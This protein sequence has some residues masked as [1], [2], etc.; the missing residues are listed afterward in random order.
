ML[1]MSI[2]IGAMN[3]A[4][5]VKGEQ[6]APHDD[7]VPPDVLGGDNIWTTDADWW[8][9]PGDNIFHENKTIL[10][11]GNLYVNGSL[12]LTNVTLEMGNATYDGKYNITVLESGNLIIQDYDDDPITSSDASILSSNTTFRF[13]FQAYPGSKLEL[14]NSE[15][16]DCGWSTSPYVDGFGLFIYTDWANITGNYINDSYYGVVVW[17]SNNVTIANN[18]INGVEDRGVYTDGAEY[19]YLQNNTLTNIPNFAFYIYNSIFI[20]ISYNNVINNPNAYG[21][22]LAN[23]GGHDVYNNTLDNNEIGV[24][25]HADGTSYTTAYCYIFE[26]DI[27]NNNRGIHVQGLDGVSAVQYIY[28]FDNEIYS[29]TEYGIILYGDNGTFAVNNTFIFD[30]KVYNNGGGGGHGIR[31]IGNSLGDV[32]RVYCLDNEVRDNNIAADTTSGYFLDSVSEIY[33]LGDYIARN[34]RNLWVDSSDNVYVTNASLEK[35]SDPGDVDIRIEDNYGNPPS[36]Y[37]LNTTFDKGSATVLDTGSFLNVQ[38]YLHIRV[39]QW[40]SGADNV[41]VW[42]NNSFGNPDPLSGQ[43]FNTNIGNDGWI[44]W[45]RV[46]EFIRT[47]TSTTYYTPHHIDAEKGSANGSADSNMNLSKEVIIKLNSPPTADNISSTSFF[48]LREQEINITANG[49]DPEDSEDILTPYFEYSDPNVPDW[50]TTYLGNPIYIGIAPSGFWQV[51][52]TPPG[53]APLGLYE[54]RVRFEDPNGSSSG[55]KLLSGFVI[56]QGNPPTANAGPDDTVSAGTTHLFNGSGSTDDE[57][58]INYTWN[59]TYNSTD[60]YLYGVGPVF[61]FNIPGVYIVT[62]RVEDAQG[63]WDT[64]S[65]QITVM[66]DA[67]PVVYAGLDGSVKVN[68]QYNFSAAGSWDNVGIVWYNWTFDDG[69]Y[70]NGTNIT[71]KHTYTS[72]G[73][74]TVTLNCSDAAGNWAI[75]TV[76]I[77]VILSDPPVAEAGP[78]NSTDEGSQIV[79]NGSASTDDFGI[80]LYYWDVDASNGLDWI[81]PDL[82]GEEVIWTYNIPGIYE[83]TLKVIDADGGWDTAILNATVNDITP[84]VANAGPT[85]STDE[86]TEYIFDGT[87][88]YDPEGGTIISYYWDFGDGNFTSGADPQPSHTYIHPGYYNVT[89]NVTDSA[90]HWDTTWVWITVLDITPPTANAGL[91]NVTDEGSPVTFDG[92]ASFDNYD[93]PGAL[94]YSWDIDDSDGVDWVTPD[95]TGS[96]PIHV[97]SQPGTY[98]VTLNV[99][100]TAG[101][102]GHDTLTIIVNDVTA[103]TANAGPDAT[104]NEDSPHTFDGSGSFD[105]V[106]IDTYAWDIDDS[107]GVDWSSPDKFG[108]N[109]SH[110][111]TDP[112]TYIATLNVTDAMGYW[113]TDTVIINVTDI[114]PPTVSAGPVDYDTVNNG[115]DYAFNGSASTDNSGSIAFYNWSFGDGNYA[116]G[117][118]PKPEHTYTTPGNYTVILTVT[119]AAGNS[120]TDTM[121]IKVIDTDDP[122]AN[123]GQNDTVNEDTPYQFNGSASTDDVGIETYA[124][125][126]DAS[127]GVDWAS[128][129]HTGMMPVHIYSDPDMYLVTLKVTDADGNWGTDTLQITVFDITPPIAN[130]GSPAT[131]DEDTPYLLDGSASYDPEGGTIAWYNWTFGDGNF[132]YGT[133]PQPFHTYVQP[134]SYTVTLNVTDTEGNWALNTTQIKVLDVTPPTAN[135]GTNDTV[136]ENSPYTFDASGSFDNVDIA[137]YAWDMDKSDGVN[138]N[139][140]DY[141]GPTW[142]DPDHIYYEPGTYIV[143]LCVND[144]SGNWDIDTVI[145]TVV[146]VTPPTANAGTNDTVNEDSPYTFD[147]SASGDNVAIAYYAWDMDAS[148]GIDWNNPDYSGPTMWDPDYTYNEPG[149]YIVTLR[150]NDTSGNWDI[151]TVIITVIDVTSPTA[152]CGPDDAVDEDKPYTLNASASTDNVGIVNYSWDMDDSDGIDWGNPDHTGIFPTHIFSE[153]GTYIVTLRTSD[154]QGNWNIDTVAIK[155]LD[156]TKPGLNVVFGST[157]DEDVEYEFNASDSS[158]NTGIVTYYFSFGDGFSV[159]GNEAVVTHVYENPGIYTLTVNLTDTA[160]NWNTGS[161]LITIRDTTP[162]LSP[163]GLSVSKIRTGGTLNISW[164]PNSEEDLNH[165]ELYFSD[166]GINFV[167]LDELSQGVSYYVHSGLLNGRNYSYH[168]VAVDESGLSSQPSNIVFAIPDKD[169]DSDGIFDSEDEDDD[170]DGVND[171]VDAFPYNSDEWSDNDGD[172]IGDN[173]DSDDDDDGVLDVNDDLPFDPTETLDTDGDG[174]GNNADKDDDDD[175]KPDVSDDYPLDS[176]KWKAPFDFASILFIFIALIS[177]IAAIILGILLRKQQRRNTELRQRVD[178]LEHAQTQ[179]QQ[180]Q[181]TPAVTSGVPSKYRSPKASEKPPK[182]PSSIS[183]KKERPGKFPPPPQEEVSET[184]EPDQTF[185]MIED[186]EKPAQMP[187]PPEPEQPPQPKKEAKKPQPPPPPE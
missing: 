11:M 178:Q 161:W 119:D 175:G 125:D 99:T 84:P 187:A 44:R 171:D 13:G 101:N 39:M 76:N 48:V 59:F 19:C 53:D 88:S 61:T 46:T 124:W 126:I 108:V 136:N 16:Y 114:T 32:G 12:T 130:A 113:S 25:V 129:D 6:G 24:F 7:G 60:T 128:P 1:I 163:A 14:K 106:G 65:V 149:T 150:V 90:S 146:D 35:S 89:L 107:D 91:G 28:I 123:A 135:A 112:G 145:I 80:I 184:P 33:I 133:D 4:P 71:P 174:V 102:S 165:Y 148:D 75:D 179:P 30:N 50:N 17:E 170:D 186:V 164:I 166:D 109:P 15:L 141:S 97:Y 56:V 79:F 45:L 96:N 158:D 69:S 142:W 134:G 154:A 103:P 177:I 10:V 64:D 27:F 94:S 67:P 8:I 92:S 137:Y 86:D 176:S 183:P 115:T 18:T 58:I 116:N 104:L 140:P 105:N 160:G 36:V 40:G 68:T 153:P 52:F 54:F 151:D 57:G 155:V 62:L 2:F 83:V 118:N 162:P 26:N 31:F 72:L 138:W 70:D 180:L 131:I 82:I 22:S 55:W 152:D 127:D 20:N 49:T 38:W 173:A 21:I 120:D 98:T 77:T 111:Y 117:T 73:T 85:D 3:F 156:V 95:H 143:T 34:D 144:T 172:G 81:T 121:K 157:M 42:V 185:E 43:P 159:S 132:S 110:I 139:N 100:D 66:D 93:D 63:E 47:S 181:V 41:K 29:N 23:G 9:E 167:K 182:Q 169:S 78:D 122:K 51:S 5:P 147:A 168:I 87:G 37:F 74:Y